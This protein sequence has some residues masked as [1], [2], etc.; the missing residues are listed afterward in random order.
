MAINIVVQDQP[1][2]ISVT[3]PVSPT[4]EVTTSTVVIEVSKG[5][6][7]VISP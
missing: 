6:V 2:V 3:T 4:I 1:T 5:T 7:T